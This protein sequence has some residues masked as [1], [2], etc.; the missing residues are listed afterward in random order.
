MTC[1]LTFGMARLGVHKRQHMKIG[2]KSITSY[3][4]KLLSALLHR[5]LAEC[6][7]QSRWHADTERTVSQMGRRRVYGLVAWVGSVARR[8]VS[9]D[10]HTVLR[11]A[12]YH[13][14]DAVVGWSVDEDMFPCRNGTTRCYDSDKNGNYLPAMPLTLLHHPG[15][16]VGWACGQRRPLRALSHMTLLYDASFVFLADDDS[17]FNFPLF[18]LKFGE[19][20]RGEMWRSPVILGNY[21]SPRP[22]QLSPKG[23]FLGG[24]GYVIG[25]AALE[26]L[27]TKEML[28]FPPPHPRGDQLDS[29]PLIC[30]LLEMLSQA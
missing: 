7:E 25:H 27:Q 30:L 11:Q 19:S 4:M 26:R 29:K 21:L 23:F 15:C 8:Q 3:R 1:S 24:A 16:E 20:V 22:G 6:V 2:V 5:R 18:E 10:Q 14:S 9:R 28:D 17:F 12:P 13:G